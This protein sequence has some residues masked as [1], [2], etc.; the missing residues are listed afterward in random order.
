MHV[1]HWR[2]NVLPPTVES[3]TKWSCFFRCHRTFG[4]YCTAVKLACELMSC[5]VEAFSH[6]SVKR[7]K[8][9][10]EKRCLFAPKVPTWIG[11][12]RLQQLLTV[13]MLKNE[14]REMMLLFIASYAFLLRLPSEGLPMAALEMPQGLE[15]GKRVPVFRVLED[16][17][18]EV[19][20]PFRKHR[21]WPTQAARGCWCAKCGMTCPVHIL[22][23]YMKSLTPGTQPFAHISSRRA[24]STLRSLLIEL[25]VP[26]A[27]KHGS[28]GF[29]RG[30]AE[31]LHKGGARLQEILAAGDWKSAAFMIYLDR[32]GLERDAVL[33]AQLSGLTD[34]EDEA[35][36]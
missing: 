36:T 17:Q 16:S 26:D 35:G 18:V 9:A 1:L 4:N 2:G 32:V 7:A 29:R 10:I 3:L 28:H 14:L 6:P 23:T 15:G 21:L 22:G 8:V 19:W 5:S 24:L 34:S 33:E 12:G 20:F 13:V 25:G 30:H 11:L 31:D 27:T